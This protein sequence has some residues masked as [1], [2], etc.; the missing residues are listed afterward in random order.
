MNASEFQALKQAII[1]DV[2]VMMQTTGQVTQYIG[3]RYVPLIA[4]PIDWSDQKEYEP[5]TIVTY[6]GNSY[7]SRQFVPKGTPITNQQ[8]WASTGNF[9]AQI[10]QYRQEVKAFEN[11]LSAVETGKAPIQHASES[12]EYGVGNSMNYGHVKL[13]DEESESDSNSGI[14]ATPKMVKNLISERFISPKDFGAVGDG[15]ADDTQ[16]FISALKAASTNNTPIVLN[17]T[18]LIGAAEI[19]LGNPVAIYG[20]VPN[21]NSTVTDTATKADI[22]LKGELTLIKTTSIAFTNVCF[23]NSSTG[24]IKIASF[25]NTFNH[26]TFIGFNPALNVIK[27]TNWNG[28]NKILSCTFHNCESCIKLDAGSD[29]DIDGCLVDGTCGSF[30]T[31]V[32]DSGYKITK[33][34]CYGKGITTLHGNNTIIE[35]NYFDGLSKLVINGNGG[36]II[37]NNLFLGTPKETEQFVIKYTS[38]IVTG[39]SVVGNTVQLGDLTKVYP[40]VFIEDSNCTYFNQVTVADN[41]IQQCSVGIAKSSFYTYPLFSETPNGYTTLFNASAGTINT[42]KIFRTPYIGYGIFEYTGAINIADII[43]G[44]LNATGHI[45]FIEI[46]TSNATKT[47]IT[48]DRKVSLSNYA[49]IKKIRVMS[50]FF[51][52]NHHLPTAG[53]R[54]A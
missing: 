45:N 3:A 32:A 25:R 15:V 38:S 12:T 24:V 40:V 30:I 2:R 17:G 13:S 28:E 39:G 7:T 34:H 21:V 46:T 42:N 53:K 14:A 19:E 11:R 1:N 26:C 18:Y 20:S 52:I 47:Q 29:G 23:K 41:N 6:Q 49:E 51:P 31:S 44:E 33:N 4:D 27:G 50:I 8:F 36:C 35:G 48:F 43:N 54:S 10:E 22:I 9:N 5:L 37:N 16:A